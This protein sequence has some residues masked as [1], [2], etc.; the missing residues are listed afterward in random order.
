MKQQCS[1]FSTHFSPP[2][3]W[4][5]AQGL[6]LASALGI[7]KNHSGTIT[8]YSEP[9]LG[10]TFNIYL[11]LSTLGASNEEEPE[12]AIAN[13]VEKL[14]LVDDEKMILDVATAMLTTIGY[15]VQTAS[16]GEEALKH[17]KADGENIDLTIIDMVMPGM[18]GE[19]L[20]YKIREIYPTMPVILASGYALNRKAA[21]IME[22]GCNGFIQKPFNLSAISQK[23]RSVLDTHRPE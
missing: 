21:A 8:C 1:V 4:G 15:S 6:G 20:F 18:D 22:G 9:G 14:L 10:S 2:R 7:I 19:T 11:P 17:I 23:I 3:R 13:G 12:E 16:G 5:G